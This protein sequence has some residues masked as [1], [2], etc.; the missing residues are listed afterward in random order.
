MLEEQPIGEG[1]RLKV[2]LAGLNAKY[3]HSSLALYSLAAVCR[4]KGQKVEVAEYTINQEFLHV[5]GDIADRAPDVVGFACYIW[6]REMALKITSELKKILPEVRIVLGGPEVSAEAAN[7]LAEFP[8]VDYVI[9]GEG[10][11]SFSELLEQIAGGMR[12]VTVEGVAQ[13]MGKRIELNGGV[14]VV[15]DLD[16]LPFPYAEEQMCELRNRIVYYES[17]R[18]CPFSC[19]YCVSAASRDVRTRSVNKVKEEMDF[20]LR[21][22]V[23]QV[24]FIDRTFNVKPEHYQEIWRFLHDRPGKTGFH[25]EIVA[26]LL[27]EEEV[28]WLAN[29]PPQLF[30]FEIGIQS[31]VES[32]LAAI[33]RHNQWNL[34]AHNVGRLM[35]NGNI[36][37]H[38]DLIVGLPQE[39]ISGFAGSFNATYSLQPNMLQIGFLKL[40]P[41]TK[42]RAEAAKYGYVCLSHPPYEILANHA[43]SYKEISRLKGLEEVFN[44]TY[45][46]GRFSRTLSYLVKT[47]GNGDAFLFYSRLSEWWKNK[48]LT[49]VPHNPDKVLGYLLDFA[50]GLEPEKQKWVAELLK[51]DVL[52]DETRALKGESLAWN[53]GKWERAKNDLW[54]SESRMKQYVPEYAFSNWRDIKRRF[55]IEVFSVPVLSWIESGREAKDEWTPVLFDLANR[56]RAWNSLPANDFS[57]EETL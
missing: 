4:S 52:M 14:R 9:Q 41:G 57:L 40:L 19:S 48:R 13:R 56:R 12:A 36:H 47:A 54:R 32:T 33:G 1:S 45:N 3:I 53:K 6:N 23:P 34:L 46:S 5:L 39:N 28:Q 21:H 11:E 8:T 27:S 25:F 26:D 15:K 24:K 38:L 50:Q 37:L 31:T 20:F 10:D 55:P 29:V 18:G 42:I 7:V 16:C 43:L 35:E 2:L 22:S 30:Q 44:Q 17:S 49:G 51:F